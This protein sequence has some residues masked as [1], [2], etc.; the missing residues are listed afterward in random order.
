M[1]QSHRKSTTI[2]F[3]ARFGLGFANQFLGISVVPWLARP[4]LEMFSSSN[5]LYQF[6]G[7]MACHGHGGVLENV[8]DNFPSEKSWS[9]FGAKKGLD[10]MNGRSSPFF[11]RSS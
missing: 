1:I 8:L 4:L 11:F 7:G 10:E 6:E 5:E 2:F 9:S 3:K